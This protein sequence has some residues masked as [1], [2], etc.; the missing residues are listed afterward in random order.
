MFVI[1]HIPTQTLLETHSQLDTT[2]FYLFTYFPVNHISFPELVFSVCSHY[3][4][5]YTHSPLWKTWSW[6][7]VLFIRNDIRNDVCFIYVHFSTIIKWCVGVISQLM[8][9]FRLSIKINC[10]S[11]LQKQ[12]LYLTTLWLCL[13]LS[14]NTWLQCFSLQ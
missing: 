9:W 8:C 6:E 14:S 7:N 12:I 2:F 1:P 13:C 10:S 3:K 5:T 11:K 4:Y